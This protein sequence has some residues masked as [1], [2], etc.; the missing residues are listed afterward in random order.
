MQY[1]SIPTQTEAIGREAIETGL[2][3]HSTL[4]AGLL[5]SAYEHCLAYELCRRNFDVRRQL[6]MPII[7]NGVALDADYR[8]DLFVGTAVIIEVKSVDSLAPIHQAQLVT[9]LK[10]SNCRLG[11]LMNFNIRL[12][13]D[14][15]K[16]LVV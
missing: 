8:I 13:K 14:G 15:L 1:A 12:F 9:H 4:G 6:I 16:R 3:V 10:L 5:E 7:Y 11:F 2:R